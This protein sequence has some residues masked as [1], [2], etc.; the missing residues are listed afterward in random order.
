MAASTDGT[1]WTYVGEGIP[2]NKDSND[3]AIQAIA[4]GGGTFVAGGTDGE[5][6]EMAYSTGK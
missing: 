3:G 1:T 2:G 4:F 6:A 5:I